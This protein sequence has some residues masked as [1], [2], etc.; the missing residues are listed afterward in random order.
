M[1]RIH[2][3]FSEGFGWRD[4]SGL[5]CS[6]PQ[7]QGKSLNLRAEDSLSYSVG[8]AIDAGVYNFVNFTPYQYTL[9]FRI[10]HYT[11]GNTQYLFNYY[12]NTGNTISVY[13]SGTTT[14]LKH[15]AG[16]TERIASGTTSA[17]AGTL[18]NL[19]C[20][21][22]SSNTIDSTN[23][24]KLDFGVATAISGGTASALGSLDAS[25]ET[26]AVGQTWRRRG[27][28]CFDGRL[29]LQIDDYSWDDAE[30][31]AF[32]NAGVPTEPIV[33]PNTKFMFSGEGS[34][35]LPQGIFYDSS[36]S[37]FFETFEDGVSSYIGCDSTVTATTTNP[38]NDLQ[39]LS[40]SGTTRGGYGEKSYAVNS[41]TVYFMEVSVKGLN[42]EYLAVSVEGNSSGVLKMDN[43]QADGDLQIRRFIF[44]TGASDTSVKVRLA[45][46]LDNS[47]Y[48]WNGN[49]MHLNTW[50]SININWENLV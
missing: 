12:A 28:H 26:Y 8:N 34:N 30:V 2:A 43:F 19:I 5:T 47:A 18:Y 11:T 37:T 27:Q 40:V 22:D 14:F 32:I 25:G 49:F 7:T 36:G 21:G 33:S 39:S 50:N 17:V 46:D 4:T 6:S 1:S 9:A 29:W 48:Y 31:L 3:T 24:L 13:V 10:Q 35:S 23:Y 41:S 44:T 38:L 16:G 45:D 20:R 42:T 15:V